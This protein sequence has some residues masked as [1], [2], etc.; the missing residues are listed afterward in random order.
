M[1][2]SLQ[3]FQTPCPDKACC[4]RPNCLF[5]HRPDLPPP[6]PLV[7]VANAP[8]TTSSMSRTTSAVPSKRPAAPS[9]VRTP[10]GLTGEPPRKLQIIG[11]ASGRK[12]VPAKSS[13]TPAPSAGPPV[14]QVTPAT[15][16]VAVPVRQAMLK[17]LYDH[18]VV[19]YNAILPTNPTLASE[20]ALKQEEEIYQAASKQSYRNAMIQ[21]AASLKKRAIPDSI[22][23]DSVGTTG[24]IAARVEARNSIKAFNL[25]AKHLTPHILSLEDMNKW[26]YVTLIP[27]GEGGSNPS[28]VGNTTTCER[29]KE[30]FMVKSDPDPD[31]CLHHWGRPYTKKTAG[32]RFKVYSCCSRAVSE[33]EGCAR[34]SHVFY[35]S[36]PAIL[37]ARHAFSPLPSPSP[38][39]NALDIVALDC[40]MIYTTGGMRVARVSVID[41]TGTEVFDEIV[42]M[43]EGVHILDFNTRF[44]GINQEIYAKATRPLSEIRKALNTIMNSETILIGHAL[45]NDLKTLRIIH[46][47]CVDTAIMFPHPH[48]PPYRRALRDLA[49]Q[50]L[51]VK[52]QAGGSTVGH[53]SVEDSV[54]TLDLVRW[55]FVN[56]QPKVL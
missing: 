39:H 12:S 3:L 37:H 10:S 35:E 26:N 22:L 40:E 2:S 5:S 11:P 52:I 23:H 15:S 1:F 34:G 27:P 28:L 9:P 7:T 17:T 16:R 25:T 20:H 8:A 50:H 38:S 46:H 54:A 29:C 44:S 55:F 4:T 32:D 49:R 33:V 6:P 51:G 24:E 56:G 48:G 45:E 31:E 19:L 18:F 14:L 43:D 42:Q 47:R 41:A 53:S 30:P 36:E 13:T 21:S